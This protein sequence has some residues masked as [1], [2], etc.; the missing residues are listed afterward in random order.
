MALR[1]MSLRRVLK[2]A[3]AGLKGLAFVRFCPH[4]RADVAPC[5]VGPSVG[6]SD[7]LDQIAVIA[8]IV[9]GF[10]AANGGISVKSCGV[11]LMSIF[12]DLIGAG[13]TRHR[14]RVRSVGNQMI[15]L[16]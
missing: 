10:D 1:I 16:L 11:S 4:V 9:H 7:L 6:E 13:I 15:T 8:V 12:I 14:L 5:I 3:I 2:C